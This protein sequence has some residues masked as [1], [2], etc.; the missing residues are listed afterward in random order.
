MES[1]VHPFFVIR[2]HPIL[3]HQANVK[4][5][6]SIQIRSPNVKLPAHPAFGGTGNVPAKKFW[7]WILDIH[8]T[9]ACL[10]V[11]RDFEIWILVISFSLLRSSCSQE[12]LSIH[13]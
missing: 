12:G 3:F 1:P 10:P 11:G 7:N 8:L 13:P 9:F 2:H 4:F 6:M 5:Q